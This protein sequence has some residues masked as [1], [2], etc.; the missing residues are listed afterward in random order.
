MLVGDFAPFK[1]HHDNMRQRD[2][3]PGRRNAGKHV[4]NRAVV[5]EIDDQLVHHLVAAH[6]ARDPLD[7]RIGGHLSD[8]MGGGKKDPTRRAAPAPGRGGILA[9]TVPPPGL[10]SFRPPPPPPPPPPAPHPTPP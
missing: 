7:A 9:L 6:R 3:P 4:V 1:F 2:L 8:E 10:P 5:R